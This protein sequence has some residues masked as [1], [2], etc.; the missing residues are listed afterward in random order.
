MNSDAP[1][2][3]PIQLTA[4]NRAPGSKESPVKIRRDAALIGIPISQDVF[5]FFR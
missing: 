2:F 3:F 5:D 1:H 4:Q